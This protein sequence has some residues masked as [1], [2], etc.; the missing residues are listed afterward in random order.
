MSLPPRTA[1]GLSEDEQY[2]LGLLAVAESGPRKGGFWFKEVTVSNTE[3]IYFS[4]ESNE[5]LL[6]KDL[7]QVVLKD[8]GKSEGGVCRDTKRI[9][10]VF[11][12]VA[13]PPQ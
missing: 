9:S 10:L 12:N 13:K 1:A 4:C 2:W 5:Y 8:V 3:D 7:K 6:I 11:K